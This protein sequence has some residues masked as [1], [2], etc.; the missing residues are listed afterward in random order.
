LPLITVMTADEIRAEN[1][2]GDLKRQSITTYTISAC[3]RNCNKILT[4]TPKFRGPAMQH[5]GI[6]SD[7]KIVDKSIN[8]G[9]RP[10]TGSICKTTYISVCIHGIATRCFT[11][12][13]GQAMIR[14]NNNGPA[15]NDILW[16]KVSWEDLWSACVKPT[17][18]DLFTT[19]IIIWHKWMRLWWMTMRWVT[20]SGQEAR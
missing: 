12:V 7:I 1:Q 11:C 18:G 14:T 2:D 8:Q 4:A 10:Q 9:W 5:V 13:W 16:M 19:T 20:W 3:I 6:L 15:K 17:A